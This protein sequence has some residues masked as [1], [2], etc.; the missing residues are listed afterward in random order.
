MPLLA[1]VDRQG[2][3]REQHEGEETDYFDVHPEENMRKSVERLLNGG[4]A[5]AKK[6]APKKKG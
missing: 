5:G 3:I 4:A 6:S 2:N 1:F